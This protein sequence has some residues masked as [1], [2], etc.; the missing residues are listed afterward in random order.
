MG[1]KRRYWRA[2][3]A[4]LAGFAALLCS[5]I[6]VADEP[7]ELRA[8]LLCRTEKSYVICTLPVSVPPGARITYAETRLLNVPE[9]LQPAGATTFDANK[10]NKPS[11]KLGFVVKKPGKGTLGVE[12]RVVVCTNT[13]YCPHI[14]KAVATEIAVG[15]S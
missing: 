1:E 4:L 11:L 6:G 10:Q 2:S 12:A 8:A 3:K 13:P 14:E 9:F 15:G 7:I 5:S